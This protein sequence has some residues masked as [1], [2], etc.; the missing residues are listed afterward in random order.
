MRE[1]ICRFT[2]LVTAAVALMAGGV[3][4]HRLLDSD[5]DDGDSRIC[6]GGSGLPGESAKIG[7]PQGGG[8]TDIEGSRGR[9]FAAMRPR[10]QV[11]A[12]PRKNGSSVREAGDGM[13]SHVIMVGGSFAQVVDVVTAR[14][15][16]D[17][18]LSGF[19]PAVAVSSDGRYA[20]VAVNRPTG[21]AD[22]VEAIDFTTM[23]KAGSVKLPVDC[24]P[25]G[26]AFLRNSTDFFVT[27][28]D[29]DA[30]FRYDLLGP[31]GQEPV[32]EITGCSGAGAV[33][34]TADGARGLFSC[35][36]RIQIYDVR[37]RTVGHEL[38][39]FEKI[40]AIAVNTPGT[41]AYVADW[42][43][44]A[45]YVHVVDVEA[46]RILNSVEVDRTPDDVFLSPNEHIVYV[47][48]S[49]SSDLILL[50]A[51][52]TLIGRAR[53]PFFPLSGAAIRVPAGAA[54]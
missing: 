8:W 44:A 4:C 47:I 20:A 21:E 25:V 34:F 11:P 48:G 35:A 17:I 6:V 42:G 14:V 50:D 1:T 49:G 12:E 29:R 37:S 52:G 15:V 54:F 24:T 32:E 36:D 31:A 45:G 13:A 26:I 10:P 38:A 3:A 40:D 46:Y 27:C 53:I 41:R 23:A 39:G 2:L 16:A 33:V 9:E 43:A 51:G 18:E 28:S 7:D 22:L 19:P 30:A 5:D